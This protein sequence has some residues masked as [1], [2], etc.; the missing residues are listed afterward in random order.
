[1]INV[2]LAFNRPLQDRLDTEGNSVTPEQWLPQDYGG[3]W[4][5]T[6]WREPT[7]AAKQ[8]NVFDV[9]LPDDALPKIEA[10]YPDMIVVGEWDNNTGAKRRS[11]HARA[12][13]VMPDNVERDKDG[14]EISRT[15]P[16]TL[17]DHHVWAGVAPRDWG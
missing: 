16:T 8:R 11:I 2:L 6:A 17:R 12:I 14:N 7:I 3:S 4:V 15:R 9:L 1:M 13:D 10:D 5:R